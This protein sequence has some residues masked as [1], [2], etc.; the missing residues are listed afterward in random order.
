MKPSKPSKPTKKD[1]AWQQQIEKHV[2]TE[3]VKL[4]NPSGK[5][6]F[7]KLLNKPFKKK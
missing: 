5:E 3:K 7:F 4:E 6:Q 1:I 2:K